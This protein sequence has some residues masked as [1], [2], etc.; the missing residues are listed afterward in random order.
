MVTVPA[1]KHQPKAFKGAFRAV[2]LEL[3]AI[4][5]TATQTGNWQT[6]ARAE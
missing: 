6:R 5:S 2:L 4:V 1:Q 3:L